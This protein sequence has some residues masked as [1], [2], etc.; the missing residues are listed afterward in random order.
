[1]LHT[2]KFKVT[3]AG[4]VATVEY[5]DENAFYNTELSKKQIHEVFDHAQKYVDSCAES[6]S[7]MATDIMSKDD[8]IDQVNF[9]MPYGTSKRGQV[10]IKT[11]RKVTFPS[12]VKGN[13]DIVRSDMRVVVKDPQSKVKKSRLKEMQHK[14]TEILLS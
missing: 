4:N 6:A 8:K 14:M 10:D 9:T 13:D 7:E 3:K 12:M 11:K 5:E 1:M 2:D